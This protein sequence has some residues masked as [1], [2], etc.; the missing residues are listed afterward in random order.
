MYCETF[1]NIH[2]GHLCISLCTT[3]ENRP[4]ICSQVVNAGVTACKTR[5]K[6]CNPFLVKIVKK[7]FKQKWIQLT[8]CNCLALRPCAFQHLRTCVFSNLR[9]MRMD[10]RRMEQVSKY[11]R[12]N[13]WMNAHVSINLSDPT[14]NQFAYTP[15]LDKIQPFRWDNA[16]PRMLHRY[17]WFQRT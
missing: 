8:L 12:Q 7:I 9:M 1:G 4:W 6:K 10:R 2:H 5:T 14:R 15:N 16:F 3:S 11:F 13:I 17:E